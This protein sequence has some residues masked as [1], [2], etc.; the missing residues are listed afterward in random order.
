MEDRRLFLM[1][2]RRDFIWRR[3]E[4]DIINESCI[5]ATYNQR[6]KKVRQTQVAPVE[7]GKSSEGFTV[8]QELMECLIGVAY[9]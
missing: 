5:V 9:L 6:S 8:I 4:E 3:D 7:G 1:L 2:V